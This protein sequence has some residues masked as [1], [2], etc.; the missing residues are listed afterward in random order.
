MVGG[1]GALGALGS[2]GGGVSQGMND[3]ARRL[4][5]YSQMA[6][7][8]AQQ[9][10]QGAAGNAMGGLD[11]VT[12]ATAPAPQ[13]SPLAGI[14]AKLGIGG[15]PPAQPAPA[16]PP[17]Q[18]PQ[19]GASSQA[20]PQPQATPQAGQ[21]PVAPQA[22][23]APPAPGLAQL[24]QMSLPEI[25]QAVRKANPSLTGQPLFLAVQN[26]QSVMNPLTRQQLV[27][28]GDQV[29]M[30]GQDMTQ[31][32]SQERV[33]ATERGQDLTHGD[34]QDTLTERKSEFQQRQES[35]QGRFEKTLSEKEAALAQAGTIAERRNI[36]K[37]GEDA[38]KDDL[39]ASRAEISAAN[40]VGPER[41]RLMKE[42]AERADAAR[43]RLAAA[44]KVKASSDANTSTAPTRP[45][46][47]SS[48]A[49]KKPGDDSPKNN[50]R[51]TGQTMQGP[52]GK[53]YRYKGGDWDDKTSWE[54]VN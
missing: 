31:Q 44:A 1:L 8:A 49:A 32:N 50:N 43:D 4:M 23:N 27:L 51:A 38:I 17:M 11:G 52:D 42:T 21:P 26:L 15:A 30:R 3:V 53:T 20:A 7:M 39:A 10:G 19:Q 28:F 34:K 48:G 18:A 5:E 54:P 45:F 16:A 2:I 36:V 24:Q 29:R 41:D 6:G 35:I 37:Q 12:P 14:M 47:N 13:Q 40:V 22:N 46:D 25:V 33:G 9:Q